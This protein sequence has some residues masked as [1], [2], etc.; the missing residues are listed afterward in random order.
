[1]ETT[2]KQLDKLSREIIEFLLNEGIAEFSWKEYFNADGKMIF[3]AY[4]NDGNKTTAMSLN[5]YPNIITIYHYGNNISLPV[6]TKTKGL[7][8]ILT[9]LKS[10]FEQFKLNNL[11]RIRAEAEERKLKKIHELEEEL[12][13]LKATE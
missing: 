5:K 8:S 13:K 1:M 9:N 6:N 10:D 11:D 3:C 2:I 4:F 12:T 7:K